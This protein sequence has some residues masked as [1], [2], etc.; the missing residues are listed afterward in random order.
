MLGQL[1]TRGGGS[2][3]VGFGDVT[4]LVVNVDLRRERE[5][6]RGWVSDA[7]DTGR[8]VH[9]AL[10]L[11]AGIWLLFPVPGKYRSFLDSDYW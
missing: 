3:Q 7:G 6:E 9:V 8:D 1:E 11:V 5:R 4:G 10:C 2:L